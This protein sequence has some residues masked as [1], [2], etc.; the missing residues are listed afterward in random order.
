MD[1]RDF[2]QT[3]VPTLGLTRE[4]GVNGF[5]PVNC[6]LHDDRHVSA[7]IH[8]ETGV[9]HCFVC[10]SF[11]P[12]ALLER[13][14]NIDRVECYRLVDAFRREAN[15]T[16]VDSNYAK[17]STAPA[18]RVEWATLALSATESL[19]EDREV[20]RDYMLAK[21]LSYATLERAGLGWLPAEKTYWHKES[22]VFPYLLDGKVVGIR[23]RDGFGNKGGEPGCHFTLWGVDELDAA[24]RVVVLVEGETDRLTVLQATSWRYT[25][26]S[27]PSAMFRTE[28]KRMFDGV[29][30]TIVIPQ[31]DEPSHK[32]FAKPAAAILPN[33]RIVNLPWRRKQWGKDINDWVRLNSEQELADIIDAAA[34]SANWIYSGK[35][36]L[37]WDQ[38]AQPWLIENLLGRQQVG[39]IAGHP[40]SMKTHLALNL[41]R[42]VLMPGSP[43]CGIDSMRCTLKEPARV[44]FLEEEGD[45]MEFRGRVLRTLQNT[46]FETHTW[47]GHHLGFRLDDD[48]W[49]EQILQF[50]KDNT[51]DL[52]IIDPFQRTYSINENE[53]GEM[54]AVWNRVQRLLKENKRLSIVILHHFNKVGNIADGWNA[55]RGSSRLSAE[56]DFGI[57]V[58]KVVEGDSQGIKINIDGRGIQPVTSSKGGLFLQW[59]DE[60]GVFSQSVKSPQ[61]TRRIRVRQT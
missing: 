28:W 6:P 41:M 29:K 18:S 16:T 54:G 51:I 37:E 3:Y 9:L 45:R 4:P 19:S 12:A 7:G 38:S 39:V 55:L 61:Q 58:E 5:V 36:L 1:F 56:V 23:Y 46:P 42:C 50:T 13:L 17:A 14:T 57:F 25:V 26:V 52:I 21:G 47:Y 40:K 53:A 34:A 15:L 31:D 22:L 20:V 24:P 35:E 11:S 33:A 10:G 44:L 8:A 2:F 27:T 30:L 32:Q 43:F 48:G 49:V 59:Q 60:R